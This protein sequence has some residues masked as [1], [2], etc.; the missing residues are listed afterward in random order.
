MEKTRRK[1]TAEEGQQAYTVID[2]TWTIR[3]ALLS[4]SD[5]I[6]SNRPSQLKLSEL[7]LVVRFKNTFSGSPTL[8]RSR[9]PALFSDSMPLLYTFTT[10]LSDPTA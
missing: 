3:T 7:I 8:P 5:A 10:P 9:P 4:D 1:F 2:G 6:A